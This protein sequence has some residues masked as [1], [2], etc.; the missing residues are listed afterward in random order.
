[1]RGVRRGLPGLGGERRHLAG[2]RL[3]QARQHVRQIFACVDPQPL[4][5][6]Q[7][8]QDGCDFRARFLIPNMQPVLPPQRHGAHRVLRQV[9]V[10]FHRAV[11]QEHFQS[12]PDPQRVVTR[13]GQLASRQAAICASRYSRVA[14]EL[15]EQR[16]KVADAARYAHLRSA[17]PRRGGGRGRKDNLQKDFYTPAKGDKIKIYKP[18]EKRNKKGA[19]VATTYEPVA[20]IVLTKVQKDKSMGEL[21]GSEK[22]S[23]DYAATDANV[24]VESLL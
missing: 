6:G 12:L 20:E 14:V 19:I 16:A 15:D 17:S 8:A 18:I 10:C 22:I 3:S 1:M 24:D 7:H 13:L 23:E 11:I 4:T 2:G 21:S 5:G 9:R